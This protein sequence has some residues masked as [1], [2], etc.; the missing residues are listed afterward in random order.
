M[1]YLYAIIV[2]ILNLLQ[3]YNKGK[4][5]D[6]ERTRLGE[7]NQLFFELLPMFEYL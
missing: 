5:K 1:Q 2:S 4:F 7:I 3:Y 6:F